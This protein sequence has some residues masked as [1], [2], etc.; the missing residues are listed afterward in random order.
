MGFIIG[1]LGFDSQQGLGIFLH[2]CAQTAS[3]SHPISY[4]MGTVG[5]FPWVKAAGA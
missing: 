4:L 1:V 5:S 3:G 2:H